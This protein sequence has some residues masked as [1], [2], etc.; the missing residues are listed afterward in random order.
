VLVAKLKLLHWI[1]FRNIFDAC[2]HSLQAQLT[3][4]HALIL[5]SFW[6]ETANRIFW[7]TIILRVVE[8]WAQ[9]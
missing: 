7:F 1:C 8:F 2:L 9:W 5:N 6:K 4:I 3:N